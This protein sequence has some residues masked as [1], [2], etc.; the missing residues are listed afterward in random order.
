MTCLICQR[1]CKCKSPVRKELRR[2][3]NVTIEE[4]LK[5]A[6]TEK[7]RV[8]IMFPGGESVYPL[9]ELLDHIE[10][11]RGTMPVRMQPKEWSKQV[12]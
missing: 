2:R 9:K 1:S 7:T 11:Q 10:K 6:D 5:T 12:L 4:R 3:M 8:A